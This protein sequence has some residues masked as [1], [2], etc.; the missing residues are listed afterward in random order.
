MLQYN[1]IENQHYPSFKKK[2]LPGIVKVTAIGID[3]ISPGVNSGFH[4]HVQGWNR[5]TTSLLHR[6]TW[7]LYNMCQDETK[8]GLSWAL[9]VQEIC[10]LRWKNASNVCTGLLQLSRAPQASK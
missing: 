6:H 4:L 7:L 10:C 2:T 3:I 8:S 9:S 5:E 1:I